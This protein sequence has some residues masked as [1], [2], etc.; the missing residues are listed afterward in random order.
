MHILVNAANLLYVVAYF[1]TDMLRL[2]LMTLTAA[3]CLAAY[4]YLQPVPMLNVVA[5][6]LFFAALN[7]MQ[8]GRLLLRRRGLVDDGEVLL[9]DRDHPLEARAGAG[10]AQQRVRA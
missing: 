1:T 9:H 5:W 6:N 2:R 4:F 7:L 10:L 3:L 8:I